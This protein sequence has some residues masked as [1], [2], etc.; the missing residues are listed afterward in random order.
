MFTFFFK[1]IIACIFPFILLTSNLRG[2]VGYEMAVDLG[3][4]S[5]TSNS[6]SVGFT[7]FIS[8]GLYIKNTYVGIGVGYD[9][10]TNFTLIPVMIDMRFIFTGKEKS[11]YD[12]GGKKSG[13]NLFLFLNAGYSKS[14][15][16]PLISLEGLIIHPGFG[17]LIGKRDDVRLTITAGYKIQE[18]NDESLKHLEQSLNVSMGIKY[19]I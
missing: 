5:L 2:Q 16:N 6:D 7:G 4:Y 15:K 19:R 17:M 14:V 13:F 10:Y 18:L 3:A 1:K 9:R 12:V 8:S 11:K